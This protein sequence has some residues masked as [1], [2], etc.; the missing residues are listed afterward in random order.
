MY[1]KL[2]KSVNFSTKLLKILK[3]GVLGHIIAFFALFMPFCGLGLVTVGLIN[4]IFTGPAW[5][6]R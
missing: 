2:L 1:L 3:G 6:K 5:I 4:I